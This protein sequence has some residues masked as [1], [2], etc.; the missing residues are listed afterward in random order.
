MTGHRPYH[1]I[2]V[3][4]KAVELPQACT[5]LQQA[6]RTPAAKLSLYFD[7]FLTSSWRPTSRLQTSL[8]EHP[9]TKIFQNCACLSRTIE[10]HCPL[11]PEIF[12]NPFG[13]RV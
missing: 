7:A 3:C 8:Q 9:E 11:F 5:G 13:P 6:F 2:D 4:L 1:Q 10:P 12:P